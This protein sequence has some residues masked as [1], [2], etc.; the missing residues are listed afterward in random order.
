ML[1]PGLNW[2]RRLCDDLDF[3]VIT[4]I[5]KIIHHTLSIR[6]FVL[7]IVKT[8]IVPRLFKRSLLIFALLAL[9]RTKQVFYLITD[10]ATLCW[11]VLG[12]SK[13]FHWT[14]LIVL[15]WSLSEMIDR[16]MWNIKLNYASDGAP[17]WGGSAD[18]QLLR[19]GQAGHNTGR[20][21][22]HWEHLNSEPRKFSEKFTARSSNDKERVGS[23]HNNYPSSSLSTSSSLSISHPYFY[24]VEHVMC[25]VI[26]SQSDL[27]GWSSY[28]HGKAG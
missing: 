19:A 7:H 18:S 16:L 20:R 26:R 27:Y 2:L 12:N 21:A 8:L 13:I 24:W 22:S 25:N 10:P 17:T 1:A 9:L 11:G 5:I 6:V 23:S 3:N 28:S 14:I 15:R 4:A